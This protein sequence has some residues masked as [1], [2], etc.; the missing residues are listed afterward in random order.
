MKGERMISLEEMSKSIDWYR[1]HM[2]SVKLRKWMNKYNYSIAD[3]DRATFQ[4]KE[5]D[6]ADERMRFFF[7]FLFVD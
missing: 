7:D 3:I 1:V 4:L 5:I 2:I 6:K